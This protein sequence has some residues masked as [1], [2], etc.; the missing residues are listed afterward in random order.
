VNRCP[1]F[2][3]ATSHMFPSMAY[4]RIGCGRSPA[5]QVTGTDPEVSFKSDGKR[6]IGADWIE[7]DSP[8]RSSATTLAVMKS[9]IASLSLVLST[10]ATLTLGGMTISSASAVSPQ[11]AP[12]ARAPAQQEVPAR[13]APAAPAPQVP[14]SETV[15]PPLSADDA[16]ATLP[17]GLRVRDPGRQ[18]AF[19]GGPA[20][21]FH[22]V[23]HDFGPMTNAQTKHHRF[24]FL[25]A[26]DA[27]LIIDAVVPK[28]GC[29]RPTFDSEKVY[30]PGES[31]FIDIAFT[32]P[33]GGHQAKAIVV[34]SNAGWPAD[35][36]NIRVIGN[37]E[38]VLSFEPKQFDFGEA[39]RS[40][41]WDADVK[42][43]A[44]AKATT[45]DTVTSRSPEITAAFVGE[46]PHR[47]E[48]TIKIS[49]K[50]SVPWGSVRGGV[51]MLTTRGQDAVGV[52]LTKTLPFRISGVVV[53][54]IR[55]SE[56]IFQM[57]SIRPGNP[58]AASVFISHEEGKP[59]EV[60]DV[61][62]AAMGVESKGIAPVTYN[63][64]QVK[65][66]TRD[67]K[68]GYVITLAGDTPSD[69]HGFFG[70]TVRFKTKTV[71]DAAFVER[72]L[73]IGGRVMTE[74]AEKALPTGRSGR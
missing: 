63:P 70:G 26:G 6:A 69:A 58:F 23:D 47:G 61:V 19:K 33:T 13:T 50:P 37:V 74:A 32:P 67:G 29:T 28:C 15:A 57:R 48:V 62:L 51:L 22:E 39:R 60:T 5:T 31:G 8:D 14:A 27:P 45:F 17:E 25:N 1:Q 43:V 53:D 68:P 2:S 24:T 59:I 11:A 16:N 72:E 66:E 10:V 56:Y 65:Q 21:Y 54:E 55:A 42:V 41:K 38:S 52:E 35:V 3:D 18:P 73:P 12:P 36:F 71:G 30:Q 34:K 40:G 9:S 64:I 44:D 4:R 20:I 49:V 46:A 7:S